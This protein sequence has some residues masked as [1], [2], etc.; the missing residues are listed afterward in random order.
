M[1]TKPPGATSSPSLS[2]SDAEVL[3]MAIESQLWSLD[4]T[5]ETASTIEELEQ[6][7]A[8]I[9]QALGGLPH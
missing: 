5:D 7:V 8:D 4:R 2:S 3:L 6:V 9:W 1:A